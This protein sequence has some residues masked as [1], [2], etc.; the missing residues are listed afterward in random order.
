[1]LMTPPQAHMHLEELFS[2]GMPP[3]IMVGE[4]GAHGA[5]I[6]GMHGMG[7]NTPSFAA[8][9]AATVGLDMLWHM[10]KGMMFTMGILSM[11]FA[12]GMFEHMVLFFGRTASVPGATPKLHVMLAPVTTSIGIFDPLFLY[13]RCRSHCLT[14]AAGPGTS[15]VSGP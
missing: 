2:A 9:A 13:E 12:A 7:V 15:I 1:M 3:T 5:G 10:P 8:V 11:M 14:A 4:P 6:T